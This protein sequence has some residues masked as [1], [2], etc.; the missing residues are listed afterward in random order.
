M[1]AF[2]DKRAEVQSELS[3]LSEE[4]EQQL[5]ETGA[6]LL[7]SGVLPGEE[8]YSTLVSEEEQ[9]TARILEMQEKRERIVAIGERLAEI[10]SIFFDLQKPAYEIS[11]ELAPHYQTIGENA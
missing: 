11:S 6:A 2:T 8:P 9:A 4:L 1:S 7:D 10:E 5:A 3:S